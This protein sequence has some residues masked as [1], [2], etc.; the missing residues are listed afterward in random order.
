MGTLKP[1]FVLPP[2]YMRTVW[3]AAKQGLEQQI[4]ADGLGDKAQESAVPR[5][6]LHSTQVRS[7][8]SR[9]LSRNQCLIPFRVRERN[10]FKL[11]PAACK[12]IPRRYHC[13]I[14]DATEKKSYIADSSDPIRSDCLCRTC[15]LVASRTLCSSPRNGYDYSAAPITT[16]RSQSPDPAVIHPNQASFLLRR[17][18]G[19]KERPFIFWRKAV[20]SH[21]RIES[22][23]PPYSKPARSIA[24]SSRSVHPGYT[25]KP[26][27]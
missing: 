3:T 17:R 1:P 18:T 8:R 9:R 23:L 6:I 7:R 13:Y 20:A 22:H 12:E 26:R 4:N 5:L 14:H 11:Q 16:L 21:R 25:W 24:A 19:S 2:W 10:R 27:Q 15:P